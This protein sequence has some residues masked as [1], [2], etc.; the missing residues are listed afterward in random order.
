[1]LSTAPMIDVGH[2]GWERIVPTL[3]LC[4]MHL[5]PTLATFLLRALAIAIFSEDSGSQSGLSS[6]GMMHW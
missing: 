6:K 5:G 1:M 2:S 3:F 4:P